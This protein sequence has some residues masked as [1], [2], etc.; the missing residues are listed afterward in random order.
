MEELH[1]I[2]GEIEK[3]MKQL[4]EKAGKG[5]KEEMTEKE[6]ERLGE[7]I[8][9]AIAH[10]LIDLDGKVMAL[11][12]AIR[13]YRGG[14]YLSTKWRKC[15]EK[16]PETPRNALV[17]DDERRFAIAH[18]NG[19]TWQ[20]DDYRIEINVTHWMNLPLLPVPEDET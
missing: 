14:N 2:K 17:L 6:K 13:K 3:F 5:G 4:S 12:D 15:S 10:T 8:N 20:P 7:A 19:Y 18:W 9:Q 1:H 11:G 16:Q